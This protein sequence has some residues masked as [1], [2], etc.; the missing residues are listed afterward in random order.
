MPRTSR[1]HPTW[2]LGGTLGWV[3][4]ALGLDCQIKD[5]IAKALGDRVCSPVTAPNTLHF[6]R[7]PRHQVAEGHKF[8]LYYDAGSEE[9]PRREMPVTVAASG[10][11]YLKL[12]TDVG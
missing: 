2:K 11:E 12:P 7:E 3:S 8:D 4:S 1:C 5:W 10:E 9:H 6:A